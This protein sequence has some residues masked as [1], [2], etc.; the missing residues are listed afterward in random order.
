MSTMQ[1]TPWKTRRPGC[2]EARADSFSAPM[3]HAFL[4]FV[5]VGGMIRRKRRAHDGCAA[6]GGTVP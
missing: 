2:G 5:A 3:R 6:P 1:T 4:S